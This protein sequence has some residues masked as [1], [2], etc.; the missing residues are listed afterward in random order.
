VGAS[1]A[2]RVAACVGGGIPMRLRMLWGPGEAARSATA[3]AAV[4]AAL[5]THLP[6]GPALAQ[7][8]APAP[9]VPRPAAPP[10]PPA[11]APKPPAQP[12]Q[13]A[14]SAQLAPPPAAAALGA[15]G[16]PPK[17][18]YSQWTKFGGPDAVRPSGRVEPTGG[19]L[20]AA[21]GRSRPAR[22]SPRRSTA[23]RVPGGRRPA[24][25]FRIATIADMTSGGGLRQWFADAG[26]LPVTSFW[27]SSNRGFR[28]GRD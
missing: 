20:F 22:N 2:R 16:E 4:V 13:P 11:A 19:Q 17:L 23:S 6:P 9:A 26:T 15:T 10:R 25:L 27:S 5:A 3:C 28:A 12:A 21:S 8:P 24:A 1:A 14:Q 18:I 7:Q